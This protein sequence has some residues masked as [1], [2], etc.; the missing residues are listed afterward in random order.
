MQGKGRKSPMTRG[1]ERAV[2]TCNGS[3]SACE[4]VDPTSAARITSAAPPRFD[5]VA[6]VTSAGGLE[7]LSV[8]LRELPADFATPLVIAQ[9][10]SGQGSAL[11]SILRRRTK[12]RVEW[13]TTGARL[14]PGIVLVCP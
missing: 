5:I 6:L 10:L 1:A 2:P 7:A 4:F 12:L 11:V 14:T 9:H 8:V 3:G 13:A